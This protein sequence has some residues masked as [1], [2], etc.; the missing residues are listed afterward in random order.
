[1]SQQGEH[2]EVL[3]R[4]RLCLRVKVSV[5]LVRKPNSRVGVHYW[6]AA[7]AGNIREE[8]CHGTLMRGEEQDPRQEYLEEGPRTRAS[9]KR[10]ADQ[11]AAGE[12]GRGSGSRNY[13]KPRQSPGRCKNSCKSR[14]KRSNTKPCQGP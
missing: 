9:T 5:V 7:S 4:T 14:E 3:A 8:N 1:M 12:V 11:P 10:R 6:V 13:D 2:R